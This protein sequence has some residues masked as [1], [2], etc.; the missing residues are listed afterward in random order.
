VELVDGVWSLTGTGNQAKRDQSWGGMNTMMG[1]AGM[2]ASVPLTWALNRQQWE[3]DKPGIQ[4]ALDDYGA[5]GAAFIHVENHEGGNQNIGRDIGGAVFNVGSLF[6]GGGAVTKTGALAGKA[7]VAADRLSIAT[8]DS[9]RLGKLSTMLGSTAQGL[10]STS[11]V[12]T[13]PG[14]LALKVSDIVMPNTTTKVLDAITAMKVNTWM[15]VSKAPAAI[16][17]HGVA[18]P[19]EGMSTFLRTVDQEFRTVA[20]SPDGALGLGQM[21]RMADGVDVVAAS[22]R[23]SNVPVPP[24]MQVI[25]PVEHFPK[26]ETITETIV[27]RHADAN[28]PVSK[29]DNFADRTGLK[30]NT[31]YVVEHRTKM[32]QVTGKAVD[33]V[34]KYYTD[35]TGKVVR[36][37]TYA[38]IRG[39]WSTELNRP[40]PNVTYNVVAKVDGGLENTFTY[41]TD[42]AGHAQSVSGRITST[43][44]GDM[45]RNAWQQLLAGKRVGGL[46]YEGGHS[47][48]SFLG[49]PG[50]RIGL[51][52]QHQFQNRGFG[53]SNVNEGEAKFYMVEND[54][55]D[56]VKRRLE[57]G[58]PLDLKWT[59][60]TPSGGKPGLPDTFKLTHWFDDEIPEA[61]DF[62]NLMKVGG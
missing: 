36:V 15:S 12:L 47:A 37:D 14:S 17:D 43:F 5:M 32:N 9:A 8:M 42:A 19:L 28:F 10:Y 57:A 18:R 48:P 7:G 23:A 21:G 27:L 33:S 41:T 38:G 62:N 58:Q 13:K 25:T 44:A 30:P 1:N 40:V 50:E 3:K 20:A 54:I 60:S 61:V 4:R 46:G 49:A 45:N 39:G 2:L 11:T 31:E 55:R 35:A 16:W 56:E 24:K 52:A 22:V 51:F 53:D 29:K 34:E 26:P 59:M 6:V